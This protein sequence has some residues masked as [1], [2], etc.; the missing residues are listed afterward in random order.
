MNL[1]DGG[2]GL[3][4]DPSWETGHVAGA[5]SPSLAVADLSVLV[6]QIRDTTLA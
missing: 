6:S 4:A 1:T 5:A 2:F 3:L